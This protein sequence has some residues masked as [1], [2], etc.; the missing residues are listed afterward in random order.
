MTRRTVFIVAIVLAAIA[1]AALS[2]FLMQ[3]KESPAQPPEVRTEQPSSL[4]RIYSPVIGT[5]SAQV[6]I[7]E[8]LDPACEACSAFYPYVKDILA[9]HAGDVRL[10]IRYVPFHGDV[11]VEAIRIL[12]AARKQNLFEPVLSALLEA[13]PIWA[14]HGTPAPERAWEVAKTAGLDTERAR[15]EISVEALNALL[16]QEFADLKAAGVRSTPTFFVNG[17]LL[18]QRDPNILAEMV[19]TAVK[20]ARYVP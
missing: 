11:S 15:T 8:F 4:T 19:S 10:V 6:T 18:R 9:T 13:Q 3:R 5:N 7:V 14:D 1:T 20:N 17:Q 2:A 16:N 12:E